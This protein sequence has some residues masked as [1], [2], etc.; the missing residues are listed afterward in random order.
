MK[1]IKTVV[2]SLA[3]VMLTSC[4]KDETGSQ[5]LSQ[6]NGIWGN[7]SA[8]DLPTGLTLDITR[9]F[10][11]LECDVAIEG[12]FYPEGIT[13]YKEVNGVPTINYRLDLKNESQ[14]LYLEYD[15][16]LISAERPKGDSRT[17]LTISWKY[18]TWK[19]VTGVGSGGSALEGSTKLMRN[20]NPGVIY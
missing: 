13:T 8:T 9:R 12:V 15:I 14:D 1:T 16:S 11:T 4:T 10:S 3:M 18:G 6:F 17:Y 7:Y 19:S 20:P 5:D 2:V